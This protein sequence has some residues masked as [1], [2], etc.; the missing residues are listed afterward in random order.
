M[1]DLCEY[2]VDGILITVCY[3][4]D[5]ELCNFVQSVCAEVADRMEADILLKAHPQRITLIVF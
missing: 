4:A 5:I 2:E 3:T 1:A